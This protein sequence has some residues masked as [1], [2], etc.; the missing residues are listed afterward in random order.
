MSSLN[1][2]LLIGRLGQDPDLK[3]T[4]SGKSVVNFSLATS[5]TY[6]MGSDRQEKTE[7]HR[8]VAW[9]KTAELCSQYLAKGRLVYIEGKI[10]TREWMDKDNNKR[11]TTEINAEKVTFLGGRGEMDQPMGGGG[12]QNNFNQG[13]GQYQANNNF[14]NQAPASNQSN[15]SFMDDDDLPF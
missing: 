5:E 13:Q 14:G 15:D 8:I 10:R 11:Y 6:G 3:T 9:D 4:G 7:W 1:K 2:V 12:R